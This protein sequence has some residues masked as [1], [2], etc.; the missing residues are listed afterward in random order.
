MLLFYSRGEESA[1]TYPE[2]CYN[3]HGGNQ[4]ED[5]NLWSIYLYENGSSSG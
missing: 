1:P 3:Q 2:A 5:S 4:A